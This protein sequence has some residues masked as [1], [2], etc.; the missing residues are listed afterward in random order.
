[1]KAYRAA[2]T[3]SLEPLR[4]IETCLTGYQP[5]VPE[6]VMRFQMQLAV[7]EAT[8]LAF[9]PESLRPLAAEGTPGALA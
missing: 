3:Q 4:A 5:P 6:D 8:D 1:V 7:R 9:V 2:R